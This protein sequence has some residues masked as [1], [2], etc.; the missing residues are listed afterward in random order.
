MNNLLYLDLVSGISGDMFVG[1]LVDLGVDF[2]HLKAELGKLSLDDYHLH[3]ERRHKAQIAGVK[4]DVHLRHHHDH[5]HTHADGTRHAH[6]HEHHQ[7]SH[8]HRAHDTHA[9]QHPHDPQPAPIHHSHAAEP[10]HPQ[11]EHVDDSHDHTHRN[12]A[13]IRQLIQQ[14]RLSEWVKQRAVAV[15]ERIAVAEG[16]VH[17]VPPDQ[18]HFHEVGAVDSI[19]D[20]VAA[21]VALDSLGRPR[22]LASHVSEGTGWIRCNHGRFPLPAPATLAILGQR[23]VPISQCDEPNELVTPTGAALLAEFAE[24]FGPMQSLVANR[25]GHGL[26]TRDNQTRPNVLRAILGTSTTSQE[27]PA[28]DWETDTIAIL[29][30]NL[31]DSNGE[32]LG[33][34]V[35]RA[36][37]AGALDVFHTPVQMKKNRPGVL[38]TLLCE[39]HALNQF[40]ELIL[41]ETSAFGLR[42][43]TAERRKLRRR[44]AT[45]STPFG[46]VLM[47]QGLLNGKVLH[48][49]PEFECCRKIAT[50]A[51]LPLKTVYEAALRADIQR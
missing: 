46:P 38:L 34:F 35:Q 16:S 47:K 45:V 21:C 30:S 40:A 23:G 33:H 37:E 24:S 1:A 3:C 17:G 18:V 14:S 20:I 25:I 22:V 43:H 29:E 36:L 39:T 27:Q 42:H 41:R 8:Q 49:T 44:T 50:E 6:P 4:F 11:H 26:G 51:G 9:H 19:V 12:F 13:D 28:L 31:D 15:F 5:A 32:W 2:Q 10:S 7:E 48:S